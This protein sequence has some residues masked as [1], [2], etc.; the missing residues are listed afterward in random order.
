MQSE[1]PTAPAPIPEELSWR[2]FAGEVDKSKCYY[3][4]NPTQPLKELHQDMPSGEIQK[5]RKMIMWLES[6][7]ILLSEE[8]IGIEFHMYLLSNEAVHL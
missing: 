2:I 3:L 5:Y 6:W 1:A 8:I 7:E 4:L